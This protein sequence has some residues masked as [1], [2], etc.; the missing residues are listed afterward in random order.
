MFVGIG[1][2]VG[3]SNYSPASIIND[4]Q[5]F[6]DRVTA[7]GGSLTLTEKNAIIQLIVDMKSA[8]VWSKVKAAYPM[9]G[10]SAAGCLQNLMSAAFTGIPYNTITYAS[11]GISSSAMN[12]WVDTQFNEYN[13]LT[14]NSG[15]IAVYSRT[16]TSNNL[17]CDM[18]VFD[19]NGT[20]GY[21][22]IYS[23]GTSFG[24]R[25]VVQNKNGSLDTTTANSLG[26][27]MG[28]RVGTEVQ[29]WKNGIKVNSGTFSNTALA[30]GNIYILC[31]NVIVSGIPSNLDNSPRETAFNSIGDALT[32]A[33][34]LAY[35]TAIQTFQT[36]L[37][38]QV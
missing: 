29:S 22:Y 7:A 6:F 14:L 38:R 23:R 2:T 21:S 30:N 3:N 25:V 15:H 12:A 37:S 27:F 16:N 36:A 10:S 24:T 34:A 26:F 20:A 4:A 31:Q 17:Y 33:E 18:G 9:V 8:G 19:Q 13:N 32:D 5:A 1:N 28:N 11:T 35:Y